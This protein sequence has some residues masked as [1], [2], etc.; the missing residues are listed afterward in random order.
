MT[1]QLYLV[2]ERP[3]I[4]RWRGVQIVKVARKK[5]LLK[6]PNEQALVR[7][8]IDIPDN[9]LE[10]REV[11]VAVKPEHIAAPVVTVRSEE[12]AP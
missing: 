8:L 2:L 11:R 6:K 5:P 9:A 7:L 12:I 10:P 4:R 1:T 3:A